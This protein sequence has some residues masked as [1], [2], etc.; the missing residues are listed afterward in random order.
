MET[1]LHRLHDWQE[2]LAALVSERMHTPFSWGT[3]DCA[4]FA[5]DGVRAVTGTD[6]AAGLRGTY[7][8]AAAA[9]R[10]VQLHAGLAGLAAAALGEEVSPQQARAGDVGLVLQ[11]GGRECLAIWTGMAWH[12]PGEAGLAALPQEAAVRAWRVG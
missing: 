12:V 11:A 5:A 3:H 7:D 4:L 8:T 1:T 6:P 10:V 2:R 9:A